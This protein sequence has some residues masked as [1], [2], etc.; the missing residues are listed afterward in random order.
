MTLPVPMKEISVYLCDW[1]RL[2]TIRRRLIRQRKKFYKHK[3]PDIEIH[4]DP[5]YV[6]CNDVVFELLKLWDFEK[7]SPR[8]RKPL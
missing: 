4:P 1:E 6:T 2:E 5:T 3:Y 7:A 8:R